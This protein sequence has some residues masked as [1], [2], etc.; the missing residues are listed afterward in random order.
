MRIH[1]RPNSPSPQRFV[2]RVSRGGRLLR[3]LLSESRRCFSL[4]LQIPA[5]PPS[6]WRTVSFL[7]LEIPCLLGESI[8]RPIH[9]RDKE[10]VIY[11]LKLYFRV[12]LFVLRIRFKHFQISLK[13][14]IPRRLEESIEMYQFIEKWWRIDP[15]MF[16]IRVYRSTSDSSYIYIYISAINLRSGE[17]YRDSKMDRAV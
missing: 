4:Y 5:P 9:H 14:D 7:F 17:S 6:L 12:Y 1:R 10:E 16:S 11:T 8:G 2:S 15:R 3:L 13:F